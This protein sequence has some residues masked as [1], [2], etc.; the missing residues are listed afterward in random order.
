MAN[1]CPIRSVNRSIAALKAINQFGSLTVMEIS[2]ASDVPYPTATR[3]VQTLLAEGLIEQEPVGKRYR[4]TAMVRTLAVGFR[5]DDRLV[6]A[7]RPH[8]VALTRRTGWPIAISSRVGSAMVLLDSTHAH[9]SM[10]LG[11]CYPG[12]ELP[13]LDSAAGKLSLAFSTPE[14]RNIVLRAVLSSDIDSHNDSYNAVDL[15]V[16]LRNALNDGYVVHGSSLLDTVCIAVP[17]WAGGRFAAAMTM[18]CGADEV[19]R[20]AAADVYLDVLRATTAMID[21]ELIELREAA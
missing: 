4:P 14:E 1:G 3:I 17:I 20:E 13:M 21:N 19:P 8:I 2:R 16:S 18:V 6:R 15:S 9:T 12:Y 7:A 5:D 11:Q 10:T